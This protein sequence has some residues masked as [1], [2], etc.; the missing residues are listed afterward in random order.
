MSS[1]RGTEVEH[2]GNG[3]N[4]NDTSQALGHNDSTDTKKGHDFLS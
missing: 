1:G 2:I 3:S 4:A